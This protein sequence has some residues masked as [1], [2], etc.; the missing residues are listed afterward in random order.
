M[1]RVDSRSFAAVTALEPLPP[2]PGASEG[3]PAQFAAT[4]DPLWTIAGKPNGGY[5]LAVLGRA[6]SAVSAHEHVIAASAHYIRSPEPGPV[7]VEV[8]ILRA[9]RSASQLRTRMLQDG[10]SCVEAL[11][12]TSRLQPDLAAHWDGGVPEQA[13]TGREHA[14]RVPGTNPAG[15]PVPI[16]EQV[17]LRIDRETFGFASG[18]PAGRG[19]LRGWLEL[20][21]E[22]FD[23]VSLL[24]ALD[25]LPPATFD[26]ELTGWVPTLEL[27][28]YVRALPA[29]GPVQVLQRA[30]LVAGQRVDESCW[31]WDSRGRVVA[32]GTQ[33]AGIRLG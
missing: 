30:H 9:G 6:A 23:P 33:L 20:P 8:E 11:L 31:V 4:V 7:A 24:F 18:R 28:A 5:L 25:A 19:T 13:A 17:D 21:G 15:V 22:D 29:P 16:M 3:G 32:H 12:T 1:V 26:I 27:T 2:S 14:H 10:R